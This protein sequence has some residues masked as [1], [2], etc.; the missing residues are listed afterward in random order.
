MT[1]RD[2][3]GG[4]PGDPFGD[5]SADEWSETK[6]EIMEA[7]YRALSRHGYAGLS[8]KAIGEEFPKSSS[9]VY[10]HFDDKDDLLLAFMD[11]V[12]DEFVALFDD[13]G[14]D[15]PEAGLRALVEEAF[16]AEPDDDQLDFHRIIVELRAQSVRD[17]AYREKFRRLE[18]QFVDTVSRLLRAG[19][20]SG[21]FDVADVDT[22]AEHLIAL[23]LYGLSVRTTSGRE[24]GVEAARRIV[25]EQLDSF[26]ADGRDGSDGSDGAVDAGGS[27]VD[28]D[29]PNE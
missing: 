29:A 10:Y 2:C 16:P 20:E 4:G 27:G 17:P 24:A 14:T 26:R 12:L 8:I 6:L 1:G 9:L 21:A 5:A 19:N 18:T 25:Y 7:T 13:G 15:D 3:E 23:L 22:A 11:F 28:T